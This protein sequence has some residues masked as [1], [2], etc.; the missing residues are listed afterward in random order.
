LPGRPA[1][2]IQPRGRRR[3]RRPRT[4]AP[5]ARR[6]SARGPAFLSSSRRVRLPPRGTVRPVSHPKMEPGLTL[7]KSANC[8]RVSLRRRRSARMVRGG[9]RGPRAGT[10]TPAREPRA[11]R[12]S[13]RRCTPRSIPERARLWRRDA[14]RNALTCFWMRRSRQRAFWTSTA[15]SRRTSVLRVAARVGIVAI[16]LQCKS[17]GWQK[18]PAAFVMNGGQATPTGSGF[19]TALTLPRSPFDRGVLS[20]NQG[21]RV[22]RICPHERSAPTSSGP[23]SFAR[24]P[25]T[26]PSLDRAVSPNDKSATLH[27]ERDKSVAPGSVRPVPRRAGSY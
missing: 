1:L 2:A 21:A 19:Q 14:R 3:R 4:A 26:A 18:R 8:T 17:F 11:A 12:R 10:R 5:R 9:T 27:D 25:K 7:T 16:R 13:V 20:A 15:A 6:R 23:T 22:R 24:R